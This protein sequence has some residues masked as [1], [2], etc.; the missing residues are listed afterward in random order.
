VYPVAGRLRNTKSFYLF[1][2]WALYRVH[3]SIARK[4]KPLTAIG[5]YASGLDTGIF[6]DNR[7][8]CQAYDFFS[9]PSHD[10]D[11]TNV[12]SV[13]GWGRI[14]RTNRGNKAKMPAASPVIFL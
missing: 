4:T 9:I 13:S 5:T 6:F 12:T 11:G 8:F 3:F 10:F 14:A 1:I 7:I 2:I